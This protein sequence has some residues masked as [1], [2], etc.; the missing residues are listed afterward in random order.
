MKNK[1]IQRFI[2]F[3]LSVA[4]GLSMS[5][6][7]AFS[8]EAEEY[9]ENLRTDDVFSV[10]LPDSIPF[11]IATIRDTKDSLIASQD[12]KIVNKDKR[13]IV[14]VMNYVYVIFSDKENCEISP[15]PVTSEIMERSGKKLLY[16][17]MLCDDNASKQEVIITDQPSEKIVFNLSAEEGKN[18][19]VFNFRGSANAM[20]DIPWEDKEVKVKANYSIYSKADYEKMLEEEQKALEEE[21]LSETV[22]ETVSENVST[23]ETDSETTTETDS[24]TTTET[25]SET[26]TETQMETTSFAFGDL[27]DEIIEGVTEAETVGSVFGGSKFVDESLNGNEE[28]VDSG[29]SGG[30]SAQTPGENQG[31]KMPEET[32]LGGA[33]LGGATGDK[34]TTGGAIEVSSEVTTASNVLSGLENSIFNGDII[35]RE[36]TE[37]M[38]ETS[39]ETIEETSEETTE[40][41]STEETSDEETSDEEETTEVSTEEE[42]SVESTEETSTEPEEPLEEVSEGDDSVF[43]G[44]GSNGDTIMTDMEAI[45]DKKA[46]EPEP[47]PIEPEPEPDNTLDGVDEDEEADKVEDVDM[48]DETQT[49]EVND[50][51]E[52]FADESEAVIDESFGDEDLSVDVSDDSTEENV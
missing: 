47:E 52:V 48:I 31:G 26:E 32:V 23:T 1:R 46:D 9:K 22:T 20:S 10:V 42:S 7:P 36:E 38:E 6:T 14:V 39:E 11:T 33:V 34:V 44:N 43:G 45:V 25:N 13:D 4:V 37:T 49:E 50:Q 16:M 51:D 27:I 35:F 28:P 2:G 8:Q 19:S 3:C 21:S 15:V 30:S 24:E 17:K 5:I 41:E 12:F 18:E 29:S 40:E